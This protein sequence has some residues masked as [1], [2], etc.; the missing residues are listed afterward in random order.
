MGMS[1][2]IGALS[3]VVL[4]F[5]PRTQL[6]PARR[7]SGPSDVGKR[8]TKSRPADRRGGV[9]GRPDHRQGL[10]APPTG[11]GYANVGVSE[12]NAPLGPLSDGAE[13][14]RANQDGSESAVGYV[15]QNSG[16]W[17]ILHMSTFQDRWRYRPGTGER[18]KPLISATSE[19]EDRAPSDLEVVEDL[20]GYR[21]GPR[22]AWREGQA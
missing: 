8:W 20:A 3:K 4:V 22:S 2:P 13:I 14:R 19:S 18:I 6:R 15:D 1:L 7:G 12:W 21:E 17:K 11:T 10:V 9:G 5:M 16:K